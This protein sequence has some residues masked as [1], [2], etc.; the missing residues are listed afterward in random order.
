MRDEPA[1]RPGGPLTR[2]ALDFGLAL[3][4]RLHL[5]KPLEQASKLGEALALY[6]DNLAYEPRMNAGFESRQMFT[7]MWPDQLPDKGAVVPSPPNAATLIADCHLRAGKGLR[8]MG[9]ADEAIQHFAA[10]AQYGPL[11]MAG[12]P[13]IGNARGD[14]NFA[15]L[16]GAPAAEA[17]LYW[18]QALVAKGD[19][20]GASRVLYEAGRNLPDYL[21]KDLNELNLAMA[22]MHGSRRQQ[23]P[24]A[25]MS[26]EQRRYA[27]LQRQQDLERSQVASRYMAQRARVT[28]EV[29]GTWELVPENKSLPWRKT[30]MIQDDAS[31]TLVSPHDGSTS[32]GKMDVQASRDVGH[33]ASRGQMM[34]Y[35]G[36]GQVR[37]MWYEQVERDVMQVTDLDGTKYE[38]RRRR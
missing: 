11:K 32:R 8:A 3:Q 31:Y 6:S 35:D 36:T 30:L 9:R 20:Q 5:A 14:S 17:Q 34:L 37:T 27:E 12:V 24:L 26:A 22:R 4:A 38:A 16:A 21:R 13:Q 19:V 15:G 29:V 2:D 23:D 10:A 28:P 18:A 1:A 33:G 25:G 7:A